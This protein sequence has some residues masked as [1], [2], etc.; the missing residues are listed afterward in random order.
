MLQSNLCDFSDPYIIV[1]RVIA[2]TNLDDATGN[3]AV[4]FKNNA[5]I[6]N[7]ISKVNGVQIRNTE[8]L[9]VV[10]PMH[11]L[12]QIRLVQSGL[13]FQISYT[14]LHFRVV[15]LSKENDKK[16]FR[17]IKIRILKNWKVE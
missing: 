6:I 12:D 2:V 3:K 17:K 14:K 8:D 5:P 9:D 15:T 4:A 16:A 13:E 10:M 1:K 11:D 7:S